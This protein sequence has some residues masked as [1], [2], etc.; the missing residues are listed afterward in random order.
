MDPERWKQ[1]DK[2]LQSAQD[3]APDDRDPF[4]KRACAGDDA[5]E[6]DVR[7]LLRHDHAAEN[8]LGN[9]AMNVAARALAQ[10]ASQPA[11]SSGDSLL[12]QTI[13]HYRIVERLGRGGMGVVYKAE[14]SRLERFVAL[15]FLTDEML[16]DPEAAHRFRRE[17]K[18][19][20]ALNHPNICTI[21][22]AGE[23]QGRS[24]I[25]ME[26]LNGA[27]LKE[28]ISAR[29]D[30][31]PLE[32]DDLLTIATETADALD[33]AH[34]AGIVHRDIK[35]A[36]IFVST[37]GHAKILDFGLAK[38]VQARDTTAG[39]IAPTVT[40]ADDL[41]GTGNVVGT[42]SY[43]SP[44]QIRARPLDARTDLFSFGVMLYEMATGRQPFSG[45]SS[46][47]I[48]EAILNRTPVSAVRLNP[49]LSEEL[50]RIIAKCLE[51]DRELRYQHASEI[52]TDLQRLRRDTDLGRTPAPASASPTA[53]RALRESRH[54]SAGTVTLAAVVVAAAIAAYFYF[55]RTP[56]LT[57]K[58]MLVLA[59]FVNTTG[60]PV[61]DDT[62][63]QG[64]S[65][66]LEQSPFLSLV[67]DERIQKTLALMERPPGARLT[68][69]VAQQICER[70][71]GAAVL[72]GRID[73]LGSKYVIGLRAN[74]CRGG[75]VLDQEQAE[76]ATKEDV[77]TALSKMAGRFR[78]RVGESL[79]TV[80]KHSTPLPD[81][82]TASLDALKAY[83]DGWRLHSTTGTSA[84]VIPLMKRAIGFDPKFA[85][86]YAWLGRLYGELGESVLST[87]NATKALLSFETALK[88]TP[89]R[90]F[91]D[92]T[93][94]QQVTGNLFEAR[95]TYET[96]AQT[97]PREPR[98]PSLLSGAIYPFFAQYDKAVEAGKRA[99]AIDP[100]FPFSYVVLSTAYQFLDR[101]DEA[102]AV[103]QQSVDRKILPPPL[104]VQRY[105]VAFLKGDQA[106][107]QRQVDLA[108]GREAA[109]DWV[110]QHQAM[111][112][113]FH[114]RLG[115]AKS[116]SARASNLARV[117]NEEEA[118]ILFQVSATLW[119]AFFGNE[120]EAREAALALKTS[121][122]RDITYGVNLILGLTGDS[123][124]PQSAADDL[125]KRFSKDT[126]VQVH[127]NP[128]LRALAA[129]NRGDSSK[130]LAV[131]EV[132]APYELGEPPVW[133]SGGFGSL[134]PIYVRGEILLKARRGREAETEFQKILHHP[135][136]VA[137]DPVGAMARLELARALA[138]E[139]DTAKAK[140]AYQDFFTLWKNA[141]PD[142]PVLKQ[143]HAEFDKL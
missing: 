71:A 66:E 97:Y 78:S 126:A 114:G 46:G 85:L 113:A 77:L 57:D 108:K 40:I 2:I 13:S 94:H 32:M 64:L 70:T 125:E 35:P 132:V 118:A 99:L 112:L 12:G 31:R 123:S 92:A 79:A 82:T 61:F 48:F 7:S 93:Y 16:R 89:R 24:F 34:A 137:L 110:T 45:E 100:D 30:G 43:M 26:L 119:D 33:A 136:I 44:E 138:L 75:D 105:D 116:A 130:A 95:T 104:L 67:S 15:K 83:S 41:T 18:A 135:G 129:W 4:L 42:V 143:A 121:K 53:N 102:E 73:K 76:A 86:A 55:H 69:D 63:R 17:A 49:E 20:S 37:R 101:Y 39:T 90:Y 107:M 25:V 52:R 5:L 124:A 22:D 58:D 51:K 8:F 14:D 115:D 54:V 81:A 109:E 103:L 141:E 111:G 56:K 72:D 36:N 117:G 60:D 9:Q 131:L 10:Q 21:Y 62:L 133:N 98:A 127:Y 28:R 19:A 50:E 87:E 38:V 84:D 74:S 29:G 140:A 6:R 59:D 128:V 27:T 88:V 68:P 3:L 91:I 139:K 122:S 47:T 134:Y 65:A 120:K 96:W 23:H 106:E 1:V 142:D 11:N 80:E